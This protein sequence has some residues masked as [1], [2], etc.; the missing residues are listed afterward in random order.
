[1]SG[2]GIIEG[3]TAQAALDLLRSLVYTTLPS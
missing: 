3:V 2:A 1:M